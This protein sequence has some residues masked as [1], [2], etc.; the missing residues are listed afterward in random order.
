[1]AEF[2]LNS[3]NQPWAIQLNSG[4]N[5]VG[6]NP[7]ND[8]RIADPSV[9]SFHCE[10]MVSADSVLVQDLNSTNG[11]FI[12]GQP[13]QSGLLYLDQLLQ[14]GNVQ[15][16]L[17]NQPVQILI[18]EISSKT[19]QASFLPDGSPACLNH[20]DIPALYEC[21]K[22]DKK[23]CPSCTHV[24]RRVGGTSLCLCPACSGACE[25]LQNLHAA[26]AAPK[27]KSFFGRITQTL[28]LPFR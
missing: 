11:T 4:L 1:M 13:T 21:K 16:K 26:A 6:R 28:R 18:P 20:P 7:T 24:I 9:S 5:R 19:L 15:F 10:I 17:E 14:L 12:N 8:F 2:F 22:C 3:L 27:K 25:M 23:F